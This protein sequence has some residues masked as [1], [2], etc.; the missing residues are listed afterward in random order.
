MAVVQEDERAFPVPKEFV[1][2]RPRAVKEGEVVYWHNDWFRVHDIMTNS[3]GAYWILEN[4][5][6]GQFNTSDIEGDYQ[7]EVVRCGVFR[8]KVDGKKRYGPAG[9]WSREQWASTGIR[10]AAELLHEA[11]KPLAYTGTR[12]QQDAAAEA[13]LAYEEFARLVLEDLDDE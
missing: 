8:G 3:G 4:R 13:L 5:N 12:L 2:K 11:L 9:L 6:F 7:P 10:H 1:W